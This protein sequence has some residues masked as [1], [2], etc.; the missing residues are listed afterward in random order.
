MLHTQFSL[1][2]FQGSLG[3]RQNSPQR[4]CVT[5]LTW[6][7]LSQSAWR[8]ETRT[9]AWLYTCMA[10]YGITSGGNTIQLQYSTHYILASFPGLPCFFWFALTIIYTR[11]Q[12][13]GDK[14][15]PFFRIRVLLSM[16]TEEQKKTGTRLLY[17]DHA[18]GSYRRIIYIVLPTISSLITL[19]LD[20][21]G[22]KH[23]HGWY[24]VRR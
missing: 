15:T 1:A 3:T 24:M 19:D 11:M 10:L 13:G 5:P 2:S 17:M 14:L 22:G 6:A 4:F 16:Q 23:H 12:K 9:R 7:Q 18:N 20:L 8:S 21:H